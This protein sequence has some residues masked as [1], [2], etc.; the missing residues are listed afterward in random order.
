MRTEVQLVSGAQQWLICGL[1]VLVACAGKF[2]GSTIAARLSGL[3]GLESSALG[4]LM[5][6]RGLVELIVLNVGLDL[7]VISPTLF[8]ML[9]IMALV[10]TFATSPILDA[11]LSP[12]Y[13]SREPHAFP[14]P[15][16][17]G[18]LPRSAEVAPDSH[19]HAGTGGRRAP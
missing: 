7:G 17:T 12:E 6:T 10:T 9:V 19:E 8:A 5:N 2:G 18:S 16:R 1:I 4:V 3:S 14:V 13:R 15:R 11:I